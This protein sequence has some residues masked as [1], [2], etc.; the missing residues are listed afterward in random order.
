[1]NRRSLHRRRGPGVGAAGVSVP[2]WEDDGPLMGRRGRAGRHAGESECAVPAGRG[3]A[4]TSS[5]LRRAG[6]PVLRPDQMAA[7]AGFQG[8]TL[9]P[10]T[11]T[12]DDAR[13]V[14]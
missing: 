1:A 11:S 7:R 8:G 4:M 2:V 13:R 6:T 10:V 14:G 3:P 12:L 9:E 5:T